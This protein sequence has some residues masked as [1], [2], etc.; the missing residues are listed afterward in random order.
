MN[1]KK[2]TPT[3]YA[4]VDPNEELSVLVVLDEAT[5]Q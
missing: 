4:N 1:G 5:I 3:L 2:M